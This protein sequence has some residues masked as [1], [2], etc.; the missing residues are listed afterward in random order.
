VTAFSV[1]FNSLLV[2]IETSFLKQSAQSLVQV[3]KKVLKTKQVCRLKTFL[4]G[5]NNRGIPAI[6]FVGAPK[7]LHT[8]L[9]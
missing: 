1:Y 2:K 7:N 6:I 8:L 3:A 5:E 9:M 4:E